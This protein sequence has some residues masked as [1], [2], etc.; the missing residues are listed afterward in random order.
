MT[1]TVDPWGVL[2]ET[3]ARTSRTLETREK[4]ERRKSWSVPSRLPDP[5]P[6]D[7]YVFKWIRSAARGNPDKSNVDSR[8]QEGWE[9]VRAEDH[10]EILARWGSDQ[11][12]GIIESGGLILCKMTQEMVDQRNAYYHRQAVLELNSA[13]ENWM[14]DSDEVM[15]KFADNRRRSTFND[16]RG[17]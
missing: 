7:G 8:R 3:P 2:E 6:E 13:E 16:Q 4:S 10:P 5:Y 12:T 9:M 15:K 17:R 1:E 11:T 14:R